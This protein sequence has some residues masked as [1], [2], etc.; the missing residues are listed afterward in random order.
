MGSALSYLF[1]GKRRL[2]LLELSADLEDELD[3]G[4]IRALARE[5]EVHDCHRGNEDQLRIITWLRAVE[6]VQQEK[7][8]LGIGVRPEARN[9]RPDLVYRCMRPISKLPPAAKRNWLE[10]TEAKWQGSPTTT[11]PQRETAFDNSSRG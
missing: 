11:S 8:K 9:P 10:E 6:K 2:S 4:K 3:S 7:R 1:P 5:V